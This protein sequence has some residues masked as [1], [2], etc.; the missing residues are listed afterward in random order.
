MNH[1]GADIHIKNISFAVVNEL[2]TVRYKREIDTSERGIVE[3]VKSIG[4]PR[5][6]IIEEGSLADWVK[7]I[8]EQRGDRVVITDPKRN[9]W[10]GKSQQKDDDIDAEKLAQLHRGGYTKEVVHLDKEQRGFKGL[11]MYYHDQVTM[12]TRLK[13][14]LKAKFRQQGISCSGKTVYDKKHQEE[15]LSKLPERAHLRWQVEGY[16]RQLHEA[17]E[18]IAAILKK[19]KMV[20][21][22]YPEVGMIRKIPGFNWIT[23]CTVVAVVGDMRRF[24]TKKKLWMYSGFGMMRRK[25]SRVIYEEH[26]SRDYNRALKCAFTIASKGAIRSKDNPFRRQYH[27]LVMERGILPYR[28]ELTI[29][30]SLATTVYAMWKKGQAYDPKLRDYPVAA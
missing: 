11:V 5:I 14:K 28:A 7:E 20:S 6:V 1:I 29:A 17:D 24:S 16:M 27:R 9:R 13:N 15:W 2:G 19:M 25:S 21:R 4:K 3:Y 26:L 10:I 22:S 12:R 8:L 30:R 23:G 18:H